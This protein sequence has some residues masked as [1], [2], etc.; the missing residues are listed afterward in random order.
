[1]TKREISIPNVFISYSWTTPEHEEWVLELA[2]RLMEENG[3][4]VTLDKWDL[5]EGHDTYKFME[6]MVNSPDID[7]VLIIC[8]RGYM[9][10]A[11]AGRGGVGTEAA[12]ISPEVYT[13]NQQ[14]KFI[15]IVSE[16]DSQGGTYIPTFIKTRKYID[17]SSEETYEKGFEEL[18]RNLYNRPLYRKPSLGSAP[19]F[20]FEDA[21]IRYKTTNVIKQLRDAIV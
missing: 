3:V 8:D 18:L 15:P 11:N 9:E 21:P 20:L 17:L 1:M 13:H 5:V 2:S 16:R 6:S 4:S 10:K 12:I 14:E 19:A 7:K